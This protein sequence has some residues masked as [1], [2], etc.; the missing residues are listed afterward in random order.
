[1][2]FSQLAPSKPT[3]D[4]NDNEEISTH[5]GVPAHGST[6]YHSGGGGSGSHK[7][8]SRKASG[9]DGV[10]DGGGPTPEAGVATAA[11]SE[12]DAGSSAIKD[13]S[14]GV[15]ATKS[16]VGGGGSGPAEA[17]TP[18]NNAHHQHHQH[19]MRHKS[20]NA[21]ISNLHSTSSSIDD[22]FSP[23]RGQSVP[24]GRTSSQADS[25]VLSP[26]NNTLGRTIACARDDG[27]F[28]R[29]LFSVLPS[30]KN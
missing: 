20:H 21:V 30:F 15:A 25:S 3:R 10:G 22:I 1:M 8:H 11:T 6:G 12:G 24:G 17:T 26:H 27:F 19:H 9:G 29:I 16:G 28:V 18:S 4:A 13:S 7:H 5:H 14:C 23:C 2:A